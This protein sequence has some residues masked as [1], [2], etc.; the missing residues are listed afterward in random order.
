M[1]YTNTF[2]VNIGEVKN[3][4]ESYLANP[5]PGDYEEI[6]LCLLQLCK[7][8][9]CHGEAL[10]SIEDIMALGA[11][12]EAVWGL[13]AGQIIWQNGP[14][15]P[16]VFQ[17]VWS[18]A[19]FAGLA[20]R[21]S[22]LLATEH[23]RRT[24]S[25]VPESAGPALF[26]IRGN[27]YRQLQRYAEADASYL[28]G[29]ERFPG[30]PFL[31]FRLADLY[32]M[33]SRLDEARLLLE[34][35]RSAYPYALEMMFAIP[36]AKDASGTVIALPDLAS[37]S[38]DFIWLVA[39]DPHYAE[40]YA[41]KLAETVAAHTQ[42]RAHMHI[43]VVRDP[44]MNMLSTI[45]QRVRE[46]VPCCSTERLISLS[47]ASPNQRS[48][49]FA[50]ERF[51]L[52]AELLAKYNKPLLVTDIDI[53]CLRDPYELFDRLKD[54]DIGLT[55]FRE[56]RD[57]W[58]RYPATAIVVHPTEASIAF[59]KQ[60]ST[61]IVKLLTSHPNPWF[62]DQI[63]LFRLIEEG[64]TPVKWVCLEHILTDATSPQ[65]FFRTLHGSWQ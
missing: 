31:R 50:S 18:C 4:I 63:A 25:W 42:G 60:V 1:N 6:T 45:L 30:D 32:L 39:A 7:S 26:I 8:S 48:A 59:F 47:G 2:P 19:R 24:K 52:L 15:S 29:I 41:V 38:A 22:P 51:L 13:L 34:G 54:G 33:T 3:R 17:N 11:K 40:R 9:V 43:H 12:T 56:V 20:S 57:A 37:G 14:R 5:K 35:L 23:V 58:D 27:A 36:V 46:L 61:M 49:L 44:A 64:L 21:Y 65:A 16:E 55:K 28:A 62:A 10:S 53:E